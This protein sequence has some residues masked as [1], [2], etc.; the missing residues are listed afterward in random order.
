MENNL[1]GFCRGARGNP[2]IQVWKMPELL[3][4][5]RIGGN[6]MESGVEH[7]VSLSVSNKQV[8]SFESGERLVSNKDDCLC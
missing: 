4:H 7:I 1:W 6:R 8:S 5:L 3:N 2:A